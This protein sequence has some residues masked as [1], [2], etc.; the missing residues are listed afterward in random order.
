MVLSHP[1]LGYLLPSLFLSLSLPA[2]VYMHAYIHTYTYIKASQSLEERLI[3]H[4]A[5]VSGNKLN[6]TK[7]KAHL[8]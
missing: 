5:A 7:Q 4:E 8:P 2:Y 6:R 1:Y 3:F